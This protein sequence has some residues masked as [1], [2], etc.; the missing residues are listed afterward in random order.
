MIKNL[1]ML[2]ARDTMIN[3]IMRKNDG[4]GVVAND[5]PHWE[6]GGRARP[7]ACWPCAEW[8]QDC[9]IY[10]IYIYTHNIYI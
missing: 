2:N 8:S 7:F 6:A 4:A 9:N 5:R 3:F 1:Y 10:I